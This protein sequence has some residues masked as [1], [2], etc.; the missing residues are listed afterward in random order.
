[1]SF[2][3]RLG[4]L[5]F[6]DVVDGRSLVPL[7]H[8]D[9]DGW[10]DAVLG[11]VL[12]EGAVAPCFMIR[13]GRYKYV[14]SEPDPDQLFDLEADPNELEN[15]AGRPEHE[16]ARRAFRGEIMGR[17]DPQALKRRVIE[18]QRRRRMAY[19]ALTTG[20]RTPWDLQPDQDASG[21]YMRSHLNLDD[22]ERRARFPSPETPDPDSP[23]GSP[24]E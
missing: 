20:R 7:L 23:A 10:S 22:L 15:L 17:W 4:R 12:C 18:S 8:G 2:V 5:G 19:R 9:E 6:A 13:R 14:Y 24:S 16:E 11:E 3:A 21:R 1:M